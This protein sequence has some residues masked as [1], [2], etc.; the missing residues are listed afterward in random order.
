MIN[1]E[2][3]EIAVQGS[4][5][6][7]VSREKISE[8]IRKLTQSFTFTVTTMAGMEGEMKVPISNTEHIAYCQSKCLSQ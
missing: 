8:V 5:W 7:K 1:R 4:S 6:E 3:E 2:N